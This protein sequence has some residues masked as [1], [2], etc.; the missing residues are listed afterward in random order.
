MTAKQRSADLPDAG[1]LPSLEYVRAF[2]R[3][4]GEVFRLH[5]QLL[6]TADKLAKD[7]KIS[8]ARWQLIATIRNQPMTAAQIARR[9][10][11]S[12]Q[13]TQQTVNRLLR[14]HLVELLPNSDHR[15]S[16]LVALTDTGQATMDV[17]RERQCFLT[18]A[19]TRD[20]GLSLEQVEAMTLHLTDLREQAEN[21]DL[22]RYSAQ[23]SRPRTDKD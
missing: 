12:R 17:L 8:T 18:D 13:G 11:I 2:Q 14:Q 7:L 1:D 21:T 6:T 5:G 3:L 4:V 10:G 15:R 16:P 9:I 22:R 20:L 23:K 19:F